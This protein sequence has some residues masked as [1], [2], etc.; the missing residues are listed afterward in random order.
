MAEQK[1]SR[2]AISVDIV[3]LTFLTVS[4]HLNVNCQNALP[5]LTKELRFLRGFQL[6]AA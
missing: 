4:Q 6:L 2:V 5:K 3:K 1:S